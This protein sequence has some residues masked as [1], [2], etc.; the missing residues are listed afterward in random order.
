[1]H[2][3]ASKSNLFPKSNP[4]FYM[5][6]DEVVSL[7]L[8]CESSSSM[9]SGDSTANTSTTRLATT[10]SPQCYTWGTMGR[11]ATPLMVLNLVSVTLNSG[12]ISCYFWGGGLANLSPAYKNYENS[13]NNY[14]SISY[15][16]YSK[17]IGHLHMAKTAGSEINGELAAH[18]E[19]ACGCKG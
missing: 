6:D 15:T 2:I 10:T 1:M 8:R 13:N 5:K 18:Y 9:N 19:R 7:M 3:V 16:R 12:F 17:I 14:T 11:L 4:L